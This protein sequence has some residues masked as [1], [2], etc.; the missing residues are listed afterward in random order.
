[1]PE[2]TIEEKGAVCKYCDEPARYRTCEVCG[3]SAWIIDCGHYSQPRPIAADEYGHDICDD[4]NEEEGK[5]MSEWE[6]E[7][8]ADATEIGSAGNGTERGDGYD[9]VVYE[10]SSNGRSFAPGL[11]RYMVRYTNVA[12][13]G[14][15]WY[16]WADTEEDA[17][18]KM[19]APPSAYGWKA[20]SE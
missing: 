11:V 20:G 13:Q 9:A 1:M 5:E 17:I 15:V 8:I 10:L 2:L 6:Q 16:A 7:C 4:C 19:H 14:D 3:E 18:E 12:V